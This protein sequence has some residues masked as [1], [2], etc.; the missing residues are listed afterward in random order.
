[1]KL[2]QH[3]GFAFLAATIAAAIMAFAAVFLASNAVVG[4]LRL[5]GVGVSA[6]TD[7]LLTFLEPIAL[8][9]LW[10]VIAWS[11]WNRLTLPPRAD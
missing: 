11:L 10:V 1:M 5:T 4:F 6:W 3:P 8:L 9:G 2:D 7:E